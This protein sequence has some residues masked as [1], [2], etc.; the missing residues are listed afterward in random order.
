MSYALDYPIASRAPAD[1]R[2]AFIR[3]TYGHLAGAVLAF[4]ALET[5]LLSVPGLDEPL[6]RT[7]MSGGW[8]MVL[9]AFMGASYL[10]RYWANSATSPGLQYLGLG[11]YVVAEAVI[12]L[13]LLYIAV[14]FVNPN[15]IPQA[16]ILTLA[17]FGGLTTTVFLT[18]KDYSFLGP[19]ICIAS[20]IAV[21]V[22]VC[23]CLF[24]FDLGLV[25][26]FAMVALASAAILYT[27]S[28]V[29]LHYRTDQ[30][31]GAALELFAAVALLFW[32]IL[33]I[34]MASSRD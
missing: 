29:L 34:L 28:N 9:L 27:T 25:F 1:A 24:R 7:M 20:W 5:V 13:P 18:R 6:I 10:A 31:V 12:F 8:I 3:K 21:G 22:V 26:S 19:I 23:A 14:H 17:V 4:I 15:I 11:L 33:R 16:G 30:Y 32:Y 2:A